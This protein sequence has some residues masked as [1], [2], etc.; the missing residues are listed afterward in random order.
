[1]KIAVAGASGFIG[2]E[3]LAR[4]ET[5]PRIEKVIGFSRSKRESKS[6]SKVEWRKVDLADLEAVHSAL[7]EVDTA[8]YLVHS[9][10]PQARLSQ[11]SFEDF[12]LLQ[13]DNFARACQSRKIIRIF[14]LGGIVPPG[15]DDSP[16]LSLHLK[17]R[18]EVERVLG[19]YG[20][21][22]T[23]FR[24]GLILGAGGSSSEMLVRLV[25]RLPIMLVPLWTKT[26]SE[27][28]DV[29]DVSE[30]IHTTL[31][32]DDL[33]GQIWDLAG[34][35]K[36]SYADLMQ[37]TA[38]TLGLKR[39]I[40]PLP[41]ISP[42]VSKLWV[43]LISGAPRTLVY[44]LVKSLR[45]SMLSEPTRRLLPHIGLIPKPLTESV[46]S[47]TDACL[48]KDTTPR[49]YL[50]RRDFLG[51]RTVRSIQRISSLTETQLSKL[52]SLAERYFFWL[53]HMLFGILRVQKFTDGEIVRIRFM[54]RFT[55][56][57]LLEL[58]ARPHPER[59]IERF[60]ITGGMLQTNGSG[61]FLEFRAVRSE[62]VGLSIVQDFV[63][64]LPWT[65]YFW[66]QATIHLWVMSRF[67][68]FL[69]R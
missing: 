62:N 41:A 65:I 44:P 14:Y 25:R 35:E 60:A 15:R 9:M 28:I 32:R 20:A 5:D 55:S 53:P 34:A 58:V 26:E 69:A 7:G 43:S 27:P 38:E 3:L 36:V 59:D 30:A 29:H 48:K 33:Q 21:S 16:S 46:R 63:P 17:S 13:A 22:V 10:S 45:H 8:V 57:I 11:G 47:L 4:F 2:S 24:A 42:S 39:T 18:L 31:F 1:M 54:I 68:K 51:L 6:G 64:R 12:D 40:I 50:R 19:A 23:A 61:G 66:T 49:V 37:R 67:A 56:I 52:G